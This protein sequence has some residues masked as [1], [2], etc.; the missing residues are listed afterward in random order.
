MGGTRYDRI[1]Q[2][3]AAT[4]REDPL[5]RDR[6]VAALGDSTSVVNVG[7]G[8]GS[9]EPHDRRVVAVEPSEVM[10]AQRPAGA[11]PAV[12]A[13]AAPLPLVDDAADAAMAVI[14]VHHWDDQLEPGVRELRRIAR[15]PVVIVTFDAEVC[16]Q[17]WLPR[18]F[19]PEVT[20]LDRATFPRIEQL[21]GWLGGDVDISPVPTRRDTPD[22]TFGAFW[23]HPERVLDETA[24]NATSGF[25]RMPS[26]VVDR[27][28]ADVAASLEDG[29]WD[30]RNGHLRELDE[31][32][33]GMRL[34]VAHPGPS[35]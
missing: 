33:V 27:V 34:V 12:R 5:L 35:A 6:I 29:S 9:Y 18:D 30:E 15:G 14:T 31:L 20:V 13:T 19:L 8:T 28:V 16:G 25:A 24:R 3:Y 2:Q 10:L 21:A 1:G 7:A 32:D 22:W 26:E 23:A 4:R 11:A 17:M